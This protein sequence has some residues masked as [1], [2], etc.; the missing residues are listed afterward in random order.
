MHERRVGCPCPEST[1]RYC[2][3]SVQTPSGRPEY[4]W[5]FME[6]M[7]RVWPRPLRRGTS[8]RRRPGPQWRRRREQSTGLS[9]AGPVRADPVGQED[10]VRGPVRMGRA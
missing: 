7:A 10:G 9:C 4:N 3:P 8:S 5:S 1:D 2:R 6:V